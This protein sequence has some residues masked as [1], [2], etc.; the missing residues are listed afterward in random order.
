MCILIGMHCLLSFYRVRGQH[1]YPFLCLVEVVTM[2]IVSN[3]SESIDRAKA[4]ESIFAFSFIFELSN[5]F[6]CK[7][8]VEFTANSVLGELYF[9][10]QQMLMVSVDALLQF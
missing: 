9:Q 10:N 4:S 3:S 6:V 2:H 1:S 5:D 7:Y 8:K